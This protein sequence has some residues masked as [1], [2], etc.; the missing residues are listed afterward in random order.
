MNLQ[1]DKN[2]WTVLRAIVGDPW[3]VGA[4]PDPTPFVTF[5]VTFVSDFFFIFLSYKLPAGT[6]SSVFNLP[7]GKLCVKILFC[8]HYFSPLNTFMRK[9]KESDP[10]LW[11]TDP[12][13]PKTCGSCGS[14]TLTLFKRL[15][16]LSVGSCRSSWPMDVALWSPWHLHKK[17]YFYFLWWDS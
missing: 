6:L 1:I 17:I 12:E 5:S 11:L 3:H 13:G 8:T 14:G 2:L 16:C 7:Y 10:Y 9:G 4:D 15:T